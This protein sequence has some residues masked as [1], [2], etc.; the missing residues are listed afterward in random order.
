MKCFKKAVSATMAAIIAIGGRFSLPA[1]VCKATNTDIPQI[2]AETKSTSPDSA[3][4]YKAIMAMRSKYPEG[5]VWNN[6]NSYSWKG[7]TYTTGYGC[8]GFA[9]MLSDAA[10]GNLPARITQTFKADEVRVGDIL[11]YSGHFVTVLELRQSSFIVVEGNVNGRIYWETEK[12]H[13]QIRDGFEHHFTRYPVTMTGDVNEDGKVDSADASLVLSEY[14]LIQTG[15]NQ[16]FTEAQ[17]KAADVNSDRKTD[18]S[19][20]SK[21]L[22]Y[23]AAVSTGKNP[24]WR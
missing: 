1:C 6:N 2:T 12:T 20:A 7:G 22:E 17:K 10:F 11:H 24:T 9:F 18:S 15:G 21:I 19:D 16:T 23:Y 14:A 4:V 8:A 13:Q 5:T 3:S